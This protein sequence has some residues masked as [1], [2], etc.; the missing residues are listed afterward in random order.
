VSIVVHARG[1]FS[2]SF[3]ATIARETATSIN[4][5]VRVMERINLRTVPPP[6][7]MQDRP[8]IQ[9]RPLTRRPPELSRPPL[10]HKRPETRDWREDQG[11]RA[12]HR[13]PLMPNRDVVVELQEPNIH[14]RWL[15]R[16]TI[17]LTPV[18]FFLSWHF[19]LRA[20]ELLSR[21]TELHRELT[22]T[23]GEPWPYLDAL[24]QSV[25]DAAALAVVWTKFFQISAGA[26]GGSAIYSLMRRRGPAM[27]S[28]V[29]RPRRTLGWLWRRHRLLTVRHIEPMADRI[30]GSA[31][32]LFL[33]SIGVEVLSF[34]S[35]TGY[36][37]RW[38]DELVRVLGML[39]FLAATA[40][41]GRA[42]SVASRVPPTWS[43]TAL[44]RYL[45]AAGSFG[46]GLVISLGI[47]IALIAVSIDSIG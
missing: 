41:A 10:I 5:T 9:R 36:G 42:T 46:V 31:V 17:I 47:I 23:P 27:A 14:M 13:R 33:L 2:P 16:A 32:L 3:V 24:G 21:L 40:I 38:I 11:S 34:R 43:F 4:N 29:D 25:R 39:V 35:S 30:L 28:R 12:I 6:A 45:I 22:L 15:L 7:A 26:L 20:A 19:E 8:E 37:M 44:A 1:R 18:T